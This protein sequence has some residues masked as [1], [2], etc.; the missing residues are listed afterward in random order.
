MTAVA[1]VIR[2]D[3]IVR[4]LSLST[5]VGALTHTTALIRWYYFLNP[6]LT[7]DF[8]FFLYFVISD[9]I[10][11]L[12]LGLSF[13]LV[14]IVI[15]LSCLLLRLSWVSKATTS[16]FSVPF[17]ETEVHLIVLLRVT[18]S[19]SIFIHINMNMVFICIILLLFR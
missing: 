14:V 11:L 9:N 17:N 10:I 7:H 4:L 1:R 3:C 19:L 5:H 18:F 2:K 13:C 12:W 6:I 15:R 16:I 8:L